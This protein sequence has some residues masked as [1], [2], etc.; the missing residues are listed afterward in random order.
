MTGLRDVSSS[1]SVRPHMFSTGSMTSALGSFLE[2]E[3]GDLTYPVP[4]FLIEHPTG[5]VAVD[6]GLH[7]DLAMD[8]SRLGP[9]DGRFRVHLPADGT[10]NRELAP[11]LVG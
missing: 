9:L 10:G 8:S 11:D 2:G 1:A 6:S 4:M 3:K 7:P 5:L